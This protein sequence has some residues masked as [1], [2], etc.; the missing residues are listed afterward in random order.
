MSSLIICLSMTIYIGLLKV[1][2]V[3]HSPTEPYFQRTNF[4]TLVGFEP[5]LSYLRSSTKLNYKAS[6]WR[7]VLQA[8]SPQPLRNFAHIPLWI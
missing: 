8:S 1:R 6:F 2:R 7:R 3:Y 4:V 5:T